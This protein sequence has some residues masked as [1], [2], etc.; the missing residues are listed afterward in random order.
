M[1]VC[2]YRGRERERVR[3]KKSIVINRVMQKLAAISQMM[4]GWRMLVMKLQYVAWIS[5]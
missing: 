2:K 1:Y 4:T 3:E 5:Q